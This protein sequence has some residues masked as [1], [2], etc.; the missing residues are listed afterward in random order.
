MASE[1]YRVSPRYWSGDR[2]TWPDREK[3]LGVYLL[4]CE[5]RNTEGF[6]RMPKGYIATDLGWSP[7]TVEDTLAN[8]IGAGFVMYDHDAEVALLPGALKRQRPTTD[9]QIAGAVRKIALVPDNTLWDAFLAACEAHCPKLAEAI[10]N[11]PEIHPHTHGNGHG[12]THGNSHPDTHS[13]AP[14][15]GHANALHA[16][17]RTISISNSSS[18]PPLV[19]PLRGGRQRDKDAFNKWVKELAC[20]FDNPTRAAKAIEQAVRRGAEDLEAIQ[21]HIERWF[22]ELVQKPSTSVAA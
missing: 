6:Y 15:H 16:G 3:L 12:N 9:N 19:P 5:H 22:P 8:V 7:R 4:T 17:A 20:C 2:R 11:E 14:G 13:Q 18:V 1:H 21:A 10:R